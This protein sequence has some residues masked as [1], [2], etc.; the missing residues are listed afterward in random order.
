[1]NYRV[2]T[3]ALS[4]P[5]GKSAYRDE[6]VTSDQ[7]DGVDVDRLIGLGA[8]EVV[9]TTGRHVG[10]APAINIV[11]GGSIPAAEASQSEPIEPKREESVPSSE[12]AK[13]LARMNK[14]DLTDMA[15]SLGLT[16]TDEMFRKDIIAM[17]EASQTEPEPM[18]AVS[19]R[20]QL[21]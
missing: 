8:I 10:A 17:I 7:L 11:D 6:I 2:K 12:A 9:A 20:H 16:V 15:T 21:V 14:A 3:G 4:L 13:P 5:Q 18:D 1:M 19:E